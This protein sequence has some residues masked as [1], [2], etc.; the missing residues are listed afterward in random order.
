MGSVAGMDTISQT[1]KKFK[2]NILDKNV[3]R[4][5]ESYVTKKC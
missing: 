2:S 3:I 1:T 5:D 4:M